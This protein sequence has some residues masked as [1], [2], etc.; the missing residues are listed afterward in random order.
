MDL[1]LESHSADK[2]NAIVAELSPPDGRAD[3]RR[4]KCELSPGRGDCE[5]M[6]NA[7]PER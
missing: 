2:T 4:W 3:D 6:R 7:A 5:K 1:R